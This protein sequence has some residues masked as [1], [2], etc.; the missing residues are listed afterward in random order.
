MFNIRKSVHIIHHIHLPNDKARHLTNTFLKI[1]YLFIWL[2]WV[3]AQDHARHVGSLV[4][5]AGYLVGHA[6]S[7]VMACGIF[8]C[9]MR[10]L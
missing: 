2:R 7:L 4:G 1:I 5:H 8:S 9:G 6:G 10:D 3:L